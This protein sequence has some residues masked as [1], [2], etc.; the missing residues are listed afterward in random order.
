[1]PP[2]RRETVRTITDTICGQHLQIDVRGSIIA[3]FGLGFACSV[4]GTGLAAIIGRSVFSK[5]H[6]SKI[7]RET[8][9]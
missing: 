5:N 1:M 6:E 3:K 8:Y 2:D 9:L 4:L 7:E